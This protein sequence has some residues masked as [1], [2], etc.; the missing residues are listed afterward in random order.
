[1]KI[2]KLN[3]CEH[4]IHCDDGPWGDYEWS[5]TVTGLG[6]SY[7]WHDTGFLEGPNEYFPSLEA[8]IASIE[9]KRSSDGEAAYESFCES[10][11]GGSGPQTLNEICEAARSLK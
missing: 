1:M 9:D 8:A 5:Y 7:R 6:N 10:Y 3:E 2:I 11:Y 4:A